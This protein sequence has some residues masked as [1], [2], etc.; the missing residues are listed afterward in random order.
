MISTEQRVEVVPYSNQYYGFVVKLVRD[1]HK[2]SLEEYGFEFDIKEVTEV[3]KEQGMNS[4]V[5]LVDGHCVG[6]IGGQIIIPT[7]SGIKAYQESIWYVDKAYRRYGLRLLRAVENW[8]KEQ[9]CT[10][11]VMVCMHNSKTDKL[12]RYYQRMGFIPCETHFIKE[13]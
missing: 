1:F 5:L 11:F 9:G 13:L 2:E 8:A 6:V 7:G 10:K 4:F 12:F 3:I